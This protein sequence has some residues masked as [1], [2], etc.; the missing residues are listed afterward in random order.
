ME[1]RMRLQEAEDLKPTL[2]EL[3]RTIHRHPEL[4]FEEIETGRLVAETL[5]S[6][7]LTVETGIGKTGVVGR[8]GDEGPTIAIRADM[9]A[10]PIREQND[11]P[12]ASQV[13]GVMHACG[14]DAH[15]AMVLGA[16]MLLSGM[17]L[18]GRVRFLFQ[19]CEEGPD[20]EGKSGAMRMVDDGAMSGVDAVIAL[21]VEP[22]TETG[23][24]EVG[25]GPV[26]AAADSF[27]ATIVG[28]GCHGAFPHLG[29]DPVYVT[30]GSIHGGTA[31]NII[32]GEVRLKGTIR[33]LDEEV[34]RRLWTEVRDT[35]GLSRA[36][37]ADFE[38]EIQEGFPV[39]VNDPAMAA[40]I[41][42]VAADL[43]GADNV[44]PAHPEMG[45][46]DF[47]ILAAQAPGAMFFLGV[48]PPD[49]ER[50]L[51]LHS[52]DFDLDENALPVGA[53]ILAEV[54]RRY[55]SGARS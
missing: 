38:L 47:S 50:P 41:G 37:G 4:G 2:V 39:L 26:C 55:L 45:A 31:G 19:P 46:E 3:R 13:P 54:A 36:L 17:E 12:Y 28:D 21:H 18:S 32:P 30:V 43:L 33:S 27:R 23:K 40:L 11:V 9:D 1:I 10:L 22:R 52:A 24:I 49:C 20:D 42:G 48:K 53:A 29:T 6:L 5:S 14:H 15:T 25:G 16:A 34:R 8:L 35:F 44:L 51:Q 7:G